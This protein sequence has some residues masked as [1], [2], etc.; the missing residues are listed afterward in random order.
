MPE[1]QGER[2]RAYCQLCGEEVTPTGVSMLAH[3][4]NRHPLDFIASEQAPEFFKFANNHLVDVGRT[5]GEKVKAAL[6]R[7]HRDM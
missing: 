1:A 5:L 6:W 3:L 2:T 7:N 4:L